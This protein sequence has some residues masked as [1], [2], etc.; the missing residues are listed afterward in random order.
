LRPTKDG[1][2]AAQQFVFA[3]RRLDLLDRVQHREQRIAVF[4]DLGT[5]VAVTRVVDGQFVQAELLGHL[6]EFVV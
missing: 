5:L 4:L 3:I 2:L 1:D 6:V